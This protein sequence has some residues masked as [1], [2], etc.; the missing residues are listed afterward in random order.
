VWDL[1]GCPPRKVAMTQFPIFE[2]SA[3]LKGRGTRDFLRGVPTLAVTRIE[4]EQPYFA[5]PDGTIEGTT[6]SPLWHL[7]ELN[8][9]D[10]H[11]TL[12]LTVSALRSHK[13]DFPE[14]VQPFTL[15][16][17]QKHAGGQREV[18]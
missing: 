12:H 18:L 8:D 16:D 6:Y 3:G 14:I 13:F 15:V 7:K 2:A 9:I 17:V 11:R 5:R 4:S 1:A 10:K